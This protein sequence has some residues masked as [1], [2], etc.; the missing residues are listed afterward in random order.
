MTFVE[1]TAD[2]IYVGAVSL[3]EKNANDVFSLRNWRN[4]QITQE[5]QKSVATDHKNR[6]QQKITR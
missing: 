4:V 1:I 2:R 3:E 6:D 5:N